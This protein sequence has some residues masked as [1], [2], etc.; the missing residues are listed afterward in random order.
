MR[1]LLRSKRGEGYIDVCIIVLVVI[2]ILALFTAAAP[3]MTAK[4][5]L[6]N[7][8]DELVREAEISGRIGAETTS[9][10]RVLSEKTGLSPKIEW[11]RNGKIPLNQEFTVTLTVTLDIGF[12]GFGSVPV[13]LTSKA[14]GKSEVYWK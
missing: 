14:S 6:D 8:A 10:A 7:F 13:T 1:K 11:S 2:M 5:Q 12:G 4:M 3:V 9:R